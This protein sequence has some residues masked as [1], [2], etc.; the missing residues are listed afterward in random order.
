MKI[1]AI[2]SSGMP[3]SVAIVTDGVLEAEYTVN[4]KKTHSQTLL[5][6]IDEISKMVLLDKKSVDAIAVAAGPGS[7]TGLRIG[8]ATAK[9]IGLAWKK[10]LVAVPTLEG[11]ACN[12]Y[13]CEDL[14]CPMM[15]ARRQQVFTGIYTYEG[16]ALKVLMDQ[17]PVPVE[18]LCERLNAMAEES[19]KKIV[20]LGDGAAVYETVFREK[21][22]ADWSLAPANMNQQRASG[23]AVRAR[24][25]YDAGQIVSAADMRPEYLRVSQAER[26]R[27]QKLQGREEQVGVRPTQTADRYTIGRMTEADAA[28]AARIDAR[29]YT[30]PWSENSFREALL[31][32]NYIFLTAKDEENHLIGY[33]GLIASFDE[34]DILNVSVEEVHQGQGIATALVS[35]LMKEGQAQGIR[36]FTLEVRAGNRKA[37]GLYEKL[38]FQTEG[39]RRG[40]YEQP[41]E[42]ALIMWLRGGH[43]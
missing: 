39:I 17:E 2:D 41:R 13:G 31:R 1:L 7:F 35:A 32:D 43:V 18:E 40:F 25:M 38:G 19:G 4:Y 11:M 21:L 10:P 12:Y 23:L 36:N 16:T 9:G 42:D 15:D 29:L 27:A 20:L 8:C 33:C 22:K 26:V 30:T 24:E 34:A 14:I 37:I 3:A 6:M 28:A 5:P